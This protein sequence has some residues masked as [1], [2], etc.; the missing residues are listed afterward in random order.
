[1]DNTAGF[2]LSN[3]DSMAGDTSLLEFSMPENELMGGGMLRPSLPAPVPNTT[4]PG[5]NPSPG[6]RVDS[7]SNGADGEQAGSAQQQQDA[8]PG[9]PTTQMA[10]SQGGT[11]SKRGRGEEPPK[12]GST[13]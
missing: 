7:A 11:S 2:G 8:T 6:V 4:P 10:T 3:L 13:R 9:H 12:R 5:A 1:M